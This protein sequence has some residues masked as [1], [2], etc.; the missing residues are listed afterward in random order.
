MDG[1]GWADKMLTER[2]IKIFWLILALITL[3]LAALVF[4]E[5]RSLRAQTGQLINL[6][7]QSQILNQ[8]LIQAIATQTVKLKQIELAEKKSFYGL[9]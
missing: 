5:Y 8:K 2:Y 9:N 4:A 1:S 7:A 3:G 6:Q